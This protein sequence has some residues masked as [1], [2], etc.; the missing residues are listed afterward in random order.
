M[1]Q[2]EL[3]PRSTFF[4]LVSF[5][6]RFSREYGPR[7][8]GALS[9]SSSTVCGHNISVYCMHIHVMGTTNVLLEYF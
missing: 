6:F 5:V 8:G 4:G 2:D 7:G 9:G 1:P 3:L